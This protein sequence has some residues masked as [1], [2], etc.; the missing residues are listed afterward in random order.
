MIRPSAPLPSSLTTLLFVK[1]TAVV[2]LPALFTID[3]FF[4]D[5]VKSESPVFYRS[6]KIECLWVEQLYRRSFLFDLTGDIG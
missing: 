6:C 1:E 3:L 2:G 5:L 4:P